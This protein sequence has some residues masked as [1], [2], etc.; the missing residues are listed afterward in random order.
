MR[1]DRDTSV[2]MRDGTTLYADVYRPA[3]DGPYPVLLQRTPYDKELNALALLQMDPLRAVSRGYAVV[4]QDVRGRYRSEGEFHP[5]YQEIDD[6]FDT[7]E[8]CAAQPWSSGDVGMYG[9]SYVGAVQWLAAVARPPHLKCIVPM[10]T[11]SDYYEGWT[12]QGGAFQWGFMVGWVLPFLTAADLVRRKEDVANFPA[13][14]EQLADAVDKLH[15]TASTLPLKDLPFVGEYSS[16]FLDWLSHS[17]RDDFWRAI[18]IQERF[19]QVSVPAFNLGGWYDIFQG[20]T[21]TNFA[22]VRAS[23]AT[24][25]ARQGTRLLIGPWTHSTPT[26][27]QVGTVDFGIRSSQH[28]SV[29][30]FDV[31]GEFLRFYDYWLKGIDSSLGSEPPIRLFVMGENVWRHEHEWPLARTR[32]TSYYL[33]SGGAANSIKG[34]G[35]LSQ[36]EPEIE[37]PDV[38]LY[39]PHR[40]VPTCGGQL[41]CYTSQLPPGAFDQR[42]VEARDDVLVFKTA[43][44]DQDVE[45]TGP[46]SL[47]LWAC[48]S[49]AD[50]D[51]TGKLV[52][53]C[54]DGCARNL[55]DGIIRT[56]FHLG[57]DQPRP[58]TPGAVV[59]YRIDLGSTSNLFRRGH[60]I[61]LEISSSNFPRFDRNLN[62]GRVLGEDAEVRTAV[63]TIYHDQDHPSRLVVPVIPR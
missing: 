21:L 26:N 53:F 8:W 2:R 63:Q 42:E 62:T 28:L 48:T 10:I 14:L 39:D 24:R 34:D 4:I 59:Q 9:A 58:I 1:V 61:G 30:K 19:D 23:G 11:A 17:T 36:E 49:A 56:R 27:N 35:G 15:E 43:P 46:V 55:T 57:T 52:D 54:P 45:V 3:S 29:L 40:P 12:Y 44:L 5:F 31:D 18:S 41:C 47:H 51:F 22:G 25:E 50:T 33:H 32:F 60:R 20:G 37:R 7:V 38:Y 16:Y 6:G 13:R